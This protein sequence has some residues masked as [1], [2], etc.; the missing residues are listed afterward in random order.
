MEQET[1]KEVVNTLR[2]EFRG[3]GHFKIS[4]EI[5]GK[6]YSS[7]TTNTMAIDA[8]FDDEYDLIM[9]ENDERYFDSQYEAKESL[10]NEILSNNDIEI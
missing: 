2:K 9:D 6:I 4:I 10:V 8:A 1:E 7:V 5:Y 3:Y